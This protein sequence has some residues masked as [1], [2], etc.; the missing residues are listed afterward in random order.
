[1]KQYTTSLH[2]LQ[3]DKRLRRIDF[4][5]TL[6]RMFLCRCVFHFLYIVT[7]LCSFCTLLPSHATMDRYFHFLFVSIVLPG[8]SN[9]LGYFGTRLF[10]RNLFQQRLYIHSR[11]I[12]HSKVVGHSKAIG[13]S[14]KIRDKITLFIHGFS[15]S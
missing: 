12:G 10:W 14:D 7:S 8:C 4:G 6:L 9:L 2:G 5:R 11:A 13:L 3:A 1:M 15:I